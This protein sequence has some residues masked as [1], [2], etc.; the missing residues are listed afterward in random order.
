MTWS[1][2][3]PLLS[4]ACGETLVMVGWSTLISVAGGLPIGVLLVLTGRGGLLANGVFSK[5]LGAVVNVIRSLPFVILMIYLMPFT[6]SLVGTTIGPQA[7]IV[8]LSIGAIPFFARLVEI[9]VREVDSGF[10]E[11]VQSMGGST[12]TVVRK[13]LLPESLPALISA[14]TTTVI[15]LIGYSAMAGL[16]GGGGLGDLAVRY[17]YQRFETGLMNVTLAVLIVI[18]TAVQ[19]LGDL[20]ARGVSRRGRASVAPRLRLLRPA[21]ATETS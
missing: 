8:P 6:K 9:A 7:M 12:W 21:A 18:V 14:A 19:F 5:A 4:Q 10:V 17:G 3:Q 15:A 16:I 1:E 20:T 11:A 2:M 13:A